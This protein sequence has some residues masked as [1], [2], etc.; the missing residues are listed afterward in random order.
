MARQRLPFMLERLRRC[1]LCGIE[2]NRPALEY[3]ETPYCA[4]CLSAA[5]VES[6]ATQAAWRREGHYFKLTPSVQRDR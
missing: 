5:V 6:G 4:K 1:R 3:E 2:V